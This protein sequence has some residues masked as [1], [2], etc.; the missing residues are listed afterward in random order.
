MPE[1][2][3]TTGEMPLVIIESPFAGDVDTNVKYARA[4]M[5][6]SLNRGESPCC[7]GSHPIIISGI[8]ATCFPYTARYT[9]SVKNL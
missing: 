5:R 2:E 7:A 8:Y 6:D 1:R 4:C 9:I 3:E